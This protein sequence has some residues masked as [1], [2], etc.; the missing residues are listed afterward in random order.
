MAL[1]LVLRACAQGGMSTDETQRVLSAALQELRPGDASNA[2]HAAVVA[3]L[4]THPHP[5]SRLR[6]CPWLH[7]LFDNIAQS[8]GALQSG[9]WGQ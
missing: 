7:R 9:G 8:V 6:A 4:H 2:R 1:V 3:R 5:S